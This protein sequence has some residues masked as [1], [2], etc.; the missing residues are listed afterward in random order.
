MVRSRVYTKPVVEMKKIRKKEKKSW[1]RAPTIGFYL[2]T[3]SGSDIGRIDQ[4]P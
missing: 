2:S 3:T 1:G 4:R